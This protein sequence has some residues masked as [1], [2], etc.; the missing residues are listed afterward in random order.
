[1]KSGK[2]SGSRCLR[3]RRSCLLRTEAYLIARTYSLANYSS[4]AK[5]RHELARRSSKL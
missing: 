1:M 5:F 3:G 2:G 4:L